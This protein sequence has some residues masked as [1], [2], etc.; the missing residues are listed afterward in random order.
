MFLNTIFFNSN[1]KIKLK[2]MGNI[3]LVQLQC[4]S[5]NDN[6]GIKEMV[7]EFPRRYL[8]KH[9]PLASFR[10]G[11]THYQMVSTILGYPNT[12]QIP[13]IATDFFK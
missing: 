2:G 1:G 12:R 10:K 11:S 5:K 6:K 4:S 3:E 13:L 7:Q 9:L 8:Q